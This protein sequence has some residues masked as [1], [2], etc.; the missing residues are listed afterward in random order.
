MCASGYWSSLGAPFNNF[1]QKMSYNRMV[2]AKT[3]INNPEQNGRNS[4]KLGTQT[5][6][7]LTN[8]SKYLCKQYSW[9]YQLFNS[10]VA[11]RLL[12]ETDV[13]SVDK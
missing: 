13:H 6:D 4:C 12:N 8:M 3:S 11:H 9:I 7:S 10:N 2:Q 1:T 5:S